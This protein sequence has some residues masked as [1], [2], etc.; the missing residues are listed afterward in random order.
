MGKSVRSRRLAV[1]A[2]AVLAAA[3]A[4]AADRFYEDLLRDGIEARESGEAARAAKLLRLA[5]FGLLEEPPALGRCLTQLALAQAETDDHEGFRATF[6]RLVEVEQRF[7]GYT[8]AALS[9][10]D[11]RLFE[12]RARELVS[13]D[14]LASGPFRAPASGSSEGEAPLATGTAEAEDRSAPD[15]RER[16][17]PDEVA[18]AISRAR[19]AGSSGSR[20]VL[21]RE[22]ER[23]RP[24]AARY[25]EIRELQHLG[26]ELAYR[27]RRWQESRDFFERGGDIDPDRPA[28]G[29]YFAVALY[30]TGAVDRAAEVLRECLPSLKRDAFIEEY[31]AK[32][33]APRPR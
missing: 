6:H 25:P 11:R 17:L 10:G 29:F 1:L 13:P 26:G 16:P 19:E 9:A 15:S 18:A 14:E 20:E 21:E 33:F 12:S 24:L 2:C 22:L 3:P 32:I 7:G 30:E 23:L 28:L 4:F 8:R 5:C 31:A 27:L